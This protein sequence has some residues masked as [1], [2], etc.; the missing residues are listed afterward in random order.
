MGTYNSIS[1]RV[2]SMHGCSQIWVTN[3]GHGLMNMEDKQFQLIDCMLEN[4]W[5]A[6]TPCYQLIY[7]HPTKGTS[8]TKH[9]YQ[10]HYQNHP[11]KSFLSI[12]QPGYINH[13]WH[14]SYKGVPSPSVKG[15][16]TTFSTATLNWCRPGSNMRSNLPKR[17]TT[18]TDPCSTCV[19]LPAPPKG[20]ERRA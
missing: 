13:K 3:G 19:K 14:L 8:T 11:I 2:A 6:V 1:T 15:T 18:P 16:T 4:Q 7:D 20:N 9:M 12:I 17:R 5:R 10:H